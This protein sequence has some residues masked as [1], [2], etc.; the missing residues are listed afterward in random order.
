MRFI[1]FVIR[2]LESSDFNAILRVIN[3]AAQAYKGVIPSDLWKEP[4]MSSEELMK[5]I[6]SGVTFYGWDEGGSLLGV[7]GI[8]HIEDVTLIRHSY[9][10][11]KY[12]RKGIGSNLLKY[13]MSLAETERILVGTWA[14]ASWAIN[15]YQKHNFKMIPQEE[16]RKLLRRYWKIPERQVETSIVLEFKKS[17]E[18]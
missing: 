6:D 17:K 9:V 2:K 1:A 15:F 11:P 3:E 10:L 13:L 4:Y 14:N 16:G 7:M 5:E 18:P 12:Q 8:Q